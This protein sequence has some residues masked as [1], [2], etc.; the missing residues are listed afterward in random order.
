MYNTP[1]VLE[2]LDE[3]VSRG[4]K[5]ININEATKFSI[6]NS[7]LK[8]LQKELD[9]VSY[10]QI[11][12]NNKDI[13]DFEFYREVL[14]YEVRIHGNRNGGFDFVVIS[15]D[16]R[17]L[18]GMG[19]ARS[20]KEFNSLKSDI[21]FKI[22]SDL[23]SPDVPLYMLNQCKTQKYKDGTITEF[24]GSG[25]GKESL[26]YFL[27][28]AKK[29][30]EY[31][32]TT[33]FEN[34]KVDVYCK[35]EDGNV[36]KVY[37]NGN[38]GIVWVY[39][40]PKYN[41]RLRTGRSNIEEYLFKKTGLDVLKLKDYKISELDRYVYHG[42]KGAEVKFTVDSSFQEFRKTLEKS[43]KVVKPRGSGNRTTEVCNNG[44]GGEVWFKLYDDKGS[45]VYFE[46]S[47]NYKE[48]NSNDRSVGAIENR[49]RQNI[50]DLNTPESLAT[51]TMSN[52]DNNT[53][54]YAVGAVH[55]ERGRA[56]A[57]KKEVEDYA[58][59]TVSSVI[60][61]IDGLKLKKRLLD[62]NTDLYIHMFDIEGV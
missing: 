59:R 16:M 19:Y 13:E 53:V 25:D 47:G 39:N 58:V 41:Q 42:E 21:V 27:D 54:T 30:Y 33:D 11:I 29:D 18:F 9:E 48:P 17:W 45:C 10:K 55:N 3:N 51:I 1:N 6:K 37:L 5:V 44:N 60:K 32:E 2:L 15:P 12:A 61:G 31:L 46:N 50:E 4:R 35:D 38:K 52:S 36:L 22:N 23:I 7:E 20:E 43:F 24:D 14:G 56:L 8:K 62:P 49:M 34:K 57:S 26:E 40:D 28:S